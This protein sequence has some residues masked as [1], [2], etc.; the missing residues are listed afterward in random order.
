MSSTSYARTASALLWIRY[1]SRVF[2]EDTPGPYFK[3]VPNCV[4][5]RELTQLR[6][7]GARTYSPCA[8]HALR[9]NAET[10]NYAT[11]LCSCKLKFFTTRD[12]VHKIT[13]Q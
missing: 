3:P 7:S 5:P 10:L 13:V 1:F 4:S 9:L 8:A 12:R 11:F 6:V 2:V